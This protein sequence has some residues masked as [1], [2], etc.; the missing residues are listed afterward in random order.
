MRRHQGRKS[1]VTPFAR[2]GEQL[3]DAAARRSRDTL[4]DRLRGLRAAALTIAQSAI[5]AGLAWWAAT[6]IVGHQ[7]AFFAPI[8][9]I[10][11]LGVSQTQRFAR[12]IELVLGVAVGLLV[13][14]LLVLWIGTGVLQ[15]SLV[16]ALAMTAAVLF[17]GRPLL[18]SQAASSA[19]LVAT[20][21]PSQGFNGD[22]FIDALIGGAAGLIVHALIPA[23]PIRQVR[24]AAKPVIEELA[25][26]LD[27]V[28]DALARRDSEA[29]GAALGRARAVDGLLENL[30]RAVRSATETAR[31]APIRWHTRGM[32][33][34]YVGAEKHIRRAAANA[35]VLIREAISALASNEPVPDLLIMAIRDLAETVR[36]VGDELSSGE[37]VEGVRDSAKRAAARAG[38]VLGETRLSGSTMVAQVRTMAVDLF[39]G[40]GISRGEAQ[41]A[42]RDAA[43]KARE[44]RVP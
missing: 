1:R 2:R 24:K 42:I 35:Q 25:G 12:V 32:L 9:A 40:L 23:S 28:A 18:V 39:R 6:L 11:T 16:V 17:S 43:V 13:A 7:A 5:A 26:A 37:R 38:V 19:V 30:N 3:L 33:A 21:L 15:I 27:D 8:A 29:A 34:P 10:I 41:R 14:D 22:R 31:V 4:R 20:L 44:E 36:G